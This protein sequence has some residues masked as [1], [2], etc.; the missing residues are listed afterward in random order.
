[1]VLQRGRVSLG[2][3]A[4]PAP[5]AIFTVFPQCGFKTEAGAAKSILLPFLLLLSVKETLKAQTALVETA[6]VAKLQNVN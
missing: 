4:H 2:A 6:L 1:M 3:A 5:A